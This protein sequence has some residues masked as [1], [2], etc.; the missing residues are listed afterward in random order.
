M[1][2]IILLLLLLAVPAHAQLELPAELDDCTGPSALFCF[3]GAPAVIDSGCGAIF[4]GYAG[5]IAWPP[6]RNIGPV[7]IE[8]K[9]EYSFTRQAILPLYVEVAT[10]RGESDLRCSTSRAGRV[11]L[12]AQGAERCGGTW[13]SIGPIDLI[14]YGIALGDP[15]QVQCVF[16][17]TTPDQVTIRSIGFACIRVNPYPAATQAA[18]WG[19]VKQIFK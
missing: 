8:I 9:T 16:F 11:V 19:A 3:N 4:D 6:L 10:R 2:I 13:Q 5:R 12:V 15:Y 7:T 18:R 14:A 17:R 1:F